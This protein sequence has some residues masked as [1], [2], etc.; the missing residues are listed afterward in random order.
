MAFGKSPNSNITKILE[1]ILKSDDLTDYFMNKGKP[2]NHRRKQENINF[3]I[4]KQIYWR[5]NW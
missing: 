2:L 5:Q 3:L 1:N 4:K